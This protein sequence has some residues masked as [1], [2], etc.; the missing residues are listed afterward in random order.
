MDKIDALLAK[1]K[2]QVRVKPL[3][4]AES[5]PRWTEDSE[6]QTFHTHQV[7]VW[8]SLKRF[9]IA[10]AG[11]RGGKTRLGAHWMLREIQRTAVANEQNH[12]LIVGPNTELLKKAAL[13]LFG[14]LVEGLAEYKH[15]DRC[16]RFTPEG[17]RKLC[18]VVCEITVF[19]G[20]AN[21]PD[22]LEAATYKAVWADESGQKDFIKESW[23]AIQRRI[24][25]HRGRVI[26]TTTPYAATG[27]IRDL[28]EQVE[29]KQRDDAHLERFK[30]IANPRFPVEEYERM[31]RE[32]P[33]WRF[34]L[35]CEA[36]FT[37]PA[38]SIYDC[39]GDDHKV[40]PF[41]IPSSWP[42]YAGLDFG[43]VNTASVFLTEAPDGTLYLYADYHTGGRTAEEHVKAM[44]R[45]SGAVEFSAAVGGTWTGEDPA[46][47]REFIMAG[48]EVNRPPMKEVEAGIDRVYRQFKL[49]KLKVFK[50]CVRSV[51]ELED[52]ARE[53]DENGEPTEKIADKHKYHLADGLR[54]II[55]T[56]RPLD[57]E[58]NTINRMARSE[59]EKLPSD[60]DKKLYE[61]NTRIM[62][63]EEEEDVTVYRSRRIV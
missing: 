13:P 18:G 21:N 6:T 23:E 17:S 31:K 47:R 56:L 5:V 41:K 28:C 57:M 51:R 37:R 16:Y 20:Y 61:R 15:V 24:A 2:G 40:E 9:L 7:A 26:F 25:I 32:W 46:W 1:K 52:Y 62:E 4:D 33:E 59:P 54:Y 44:Y 60:L 38:G 11:T 48:L 22:S 58:D 36:E 8:E 27:W 19:I 12:Y 45:K 63:I 50:T 53:V 29:T 55:A 49:G 35:F 43:E 14:S 3:V 30:S 39:F 42:R 34:K 10:L